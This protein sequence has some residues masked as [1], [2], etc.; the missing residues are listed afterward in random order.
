[1]PCAKNRKSSL[2]R[3]VFGFSDATPLSKVCAI[4]VNDPPTNSRVPSLVIDRTTPLAEGAK[5]ASIAPVATS[6]AASRERLRPP[7]VVN[8]PPTNSRPPS[9]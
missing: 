5:P 3:P 6:K 4:S 2:A 8:S 9:T 7:T 1:M